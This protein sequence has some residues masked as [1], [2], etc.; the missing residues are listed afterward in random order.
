MAIVLDNPERITFFHNK[1]AAGTSISIWLTSNCN[2]YKVSGKHQSFGTMV[3]GFNEMSIDR[4]EIG[5]SFG[6]VRNPWD[7]CV[8]AFFYEKQ[9]IEN[10]IIRAE[11]G[12]TKHGSV[13]GLVGARSHY[14]M[15]FADW[16]LKNQ[17]WG[18]L[19]LSQKDF[20]SNDINLL[21]RYENLLDDF[22]LIQDKTKCN[23]E[24]PW[25][26]SSDR[27]NY[28]DY[29]TPEAKDLVSKMLQEDIVTYNYEF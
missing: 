23:I 11:Q 9:K 12:S 26:N 18:Y 27:N 20:F 13:E 25:I 22:H 19:V 28:Q 4:S 3:K 8:S 15:D 2:G 16:I 1:R 21:L 7:R 10:R 6:V 24:L 17:D 29:Y 5:F 14:N